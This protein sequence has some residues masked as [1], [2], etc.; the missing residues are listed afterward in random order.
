M[1]PVRCAL[2][3]ASMCLLGACVPAAVPATPAQEAP[4]AAP[5]PNSPVPLPDGPRTTMVIQKT[6]RIGTLDF[7]TTSK[8]QESQLNKSV[9]AALLTELKHT[10]RFSIYEAG[11]IRAQ[12]L[13]SEGNADALVDAYLSGKITRVTSR[14]VCFDVWLSNAHSHEVLY[15]QSMCAKLTAGTGEVSDSGTRD[16]DREAVQ[17][18]AQEVA[19]SVKKV[20]SG[21]VT[22]VND[23]LVYIDKGAQSDVLAGMVAYLV[24]TGDTTKDE[25]IHKMVAEFSGTKPV[26]LPDAVVGQVYIVSV[27]PDYC[28]GRLFRGDYA[29][30]G[31]TVFFK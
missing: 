31:D 21:Q 7:G 19:R 18:L 17:R 5:I 25:G 2:A 8:D 11:A 13:F 4:V 1:K 26:G 27:E 9:P 24:A 16:V 29:L 3:L 22:S 12:G 28:V 10:D 30:P 20:G 14:E 6:F 15:A 23:D